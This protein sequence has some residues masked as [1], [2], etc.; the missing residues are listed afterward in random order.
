METIFLL[1]IISVILN[2]FLLSHPPKVESK[3]TNPYPTESEMNELDIIKQ[4]SEDEKVYRNYH[5]QRTQEMYEAHTE[6]FFTTIKAIDM[7]HALLQR[8][9]KKNTKQ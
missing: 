1:L 7:Y 9:K 8:P 5:S 3:Y 6:D 2:L 4:K